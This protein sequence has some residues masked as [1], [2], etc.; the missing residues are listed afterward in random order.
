MDKNVT[1]QTYRPVIEDSTSV[2]QYEDSNSARASIGG[3]SEKLKNQ[4]IGIIGLGGS[5]SYVLDLVAKCPV[6]SIHL[7]DGDSFFQHNAF[8]APGVAALD[9]IQ[10]C[11][12]KVQYF[13]R[14][15]SRMHKSIIPHDM[16]I[17]EQNV[18]ELE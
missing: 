10:Q 12:S 15:Y 13:A 14:M 11:N 5:G 16:F 8:R 18:A 2:F 1:A 6:Q 17:H 7:Y 9:E 4:K 3:I